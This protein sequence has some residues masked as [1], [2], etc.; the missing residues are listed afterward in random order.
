MTAPVVAGTS[1]PIPLVVDVDGTLVRTDLLH[2]ASLLFLANHPFEAPRLALWLARGKATL[3]SQLA[4]RV[5]PVVER[6][7]LR[8]ETVARIRAAQAIDRPV[9]LASAS[10]ERYVARLADSIGGITG[11]FATTP[12]RNLA[13]TAKA[14]CL[15]EAFG[16]QGFDYIGDHPVDVPVWQQA[17]RQLIVAGSGGFETRMRR[18]FPD[19]EVIA[20]PRTTA[21]SMV[22]TLRA[23]QWS[24]N[25]LL[26]LALIAGHRLDIATI[27]ATVLGF[28]AFCA[29]ASSAYI[30]NDLMDLPNDRVH[31]RKRL[32]PLPSGDLGI[33]T[34]IVMSGLLLL[35]ALG[36]AV[37]LPIMFLGAL[38]LYMVATLT[39]SLLLKRKAIVDVITLAGLYTLRV[40]AGLFAGGLTSSEWLPMFSLFLFLCLAIEKRCSELVRRREAGEAR[41]EGRNYRVADLAILFPMAAAAGYGSVFVVALYLSSNEVRALY[42]H[43]ERLWLICPLLLYWISRVLILSNRNEMHDDP[44]VFALTDRISWYVAA[45]A[46]AIVGAAI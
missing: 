13:G 40:F 2:E 39:Y 16:A 44:I 33:V 11:T 30:I 29:A 22:R 6:L 41:L 7:P 24:K 34:G 12:E 17:R 36:I 27:T 32:R 5:T 28:I 21:R 35:L 23:H 14:D 46:I 9:Y 42:A 31:P 43:P 15:V 38:L 1:D 4:Q 19:A 25:G 45:C 37:L 8:D 26:F 10:D 3:K 20:R 18:A